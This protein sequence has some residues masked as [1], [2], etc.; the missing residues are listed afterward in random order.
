TSEFEND[1]PQLIEL[2]NTIT[3]HFDMNEVSGDKAYSSRANHNMIAEAGATPYIAF[4]KNATAKPNGSVAWKKMYHYFMLNNE[5]YMQHYHKRSNA[6]TTVHMIKS[7]FGDK[8]RS[9]KWTSQVNEVLCKV[10]CHNICVIIQEMH[11]LGISADFGL[12]NRV[13]V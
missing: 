8:V 1:S 7:K 13:C 10:V 3:E 9:K 12:N 6:E 11:E 2:V 4:K 5:S